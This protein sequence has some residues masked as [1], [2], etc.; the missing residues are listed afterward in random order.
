L[1]GDRQS[2]IGFGR[3]IRYNSFES[4]I[5]HHKEREKEVSTV[6][7]WIGAFVAWFIGLA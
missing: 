5:E 6:W 7:Y 4:G 1:L 3:F 2:G